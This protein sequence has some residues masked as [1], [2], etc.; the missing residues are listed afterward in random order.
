MTYPNRH[1]RLNNSSFHVTC[2]NITS[3]FW[4]PERSVRLGH[5]TI[6]FDASFHS[7]L[8]AV[9]PK[10]VLASAFIAGAPFDNYSCKPGLGTIKCQMDFSVSLNF[11]AEYSNARKIE[12]EQRL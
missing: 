3:P 7:Q 10:P 4:C 11:N 2:S 12:T 8:D 5:S 6:N 1:A 9:K